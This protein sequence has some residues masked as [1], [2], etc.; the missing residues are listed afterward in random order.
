[1]SKAEAKRIILTCTDEAE[2][3]EAVCRLQG[4]WKRESPAFLERLFE[5]QDEYLLLDLVELVS[6]YRH[7]L[8]KEYLAR[9][10]GSSDADVKDLAFEY[11]QKL[12]P[13]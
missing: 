4:R 10:S 3:W 9:L 8:T 7:P 12:N 11:L 5:F 1:M 6:E 2:L 13:H